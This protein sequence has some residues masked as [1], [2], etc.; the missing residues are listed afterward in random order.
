MAIGQPYTMGATPD[1]VD[2][3][4]PEP[5]DNTR[6]TNEELMQRMNWT[7]DDYV[8]A[9]D[10][11]GLPP[12]DAWRQTHYDLINFGPGEPTRRWDAVVQWIAESRQKVE[13]LSRLVG[14]DKPRRSFFG[15]R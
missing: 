1:S 12:A 9:R 5:V 3:A 13:R 7:A 4:P 14:D 2:A 10:G 11:F 6:V 8:T 15:K